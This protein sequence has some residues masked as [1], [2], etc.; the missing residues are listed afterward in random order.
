MS[1]LVY[2]IAEAGEAAL[3]VS[4]LGDRPLREVADDRLAAIVGD[5]AGDGGPPAATIG[6]LRAY[7]DAVERLMDARVILPARFGSVMADEGEVR[8]LLR[9]RRTDLLARLDQVRGAVELGLRATW[10]DAREATLQQR[11]ESGTEY[12]RG[13]MECRRRAGEVAR[14]LDPLAE[15]AR[16]RRRAM[17]S[18]PELPVLDAYLVDRARI[19]PFVA[20]VEEIDGHIEDVELLCT[21][22]WP[23]YSFAEGAPV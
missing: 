17:L 15:L 13:R 7:E 23:P 9:R 4:G 18:R 14:D 12:L 2:G 8:A 6:T 16:S 1:L 22:P 3:E 5:H 20:L 11:S 19:R 21:G 10:D